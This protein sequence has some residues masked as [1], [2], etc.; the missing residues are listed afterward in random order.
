MLRFAFFIISVFVTHLGVSQDSLSNEQQQQID[1]SATDEQA[2]LGVSQ[3][4][5]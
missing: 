2:D 1:Q 4:S 3:D 5:L